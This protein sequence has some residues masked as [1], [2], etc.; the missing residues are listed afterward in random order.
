MGKPNDGKARSVLESASDEFPTRILGA[1]SSPPVF[2]ELG[3][4][5]DPHDDGPTIEHHEE[6]TIQATMSPEELHAKPPPSLRALEVAPK[7]A[8][9]PPLAPLPPQVPAPVPLEL[10]EELEPEESTEVGALPRLVSIGGALS[11][12]GDRVEH[13]KKMDGAQLLAA[14]AKVTAG[15]SADASSK[16]E[17]TTALPSAPIDRRVWL[18]ARAA[19]DEAPVEVPGLE[20]GARGK[21]LAIAAI[22]VGVVGMVGVVIGRVSAPKTV[23]VAPSGSSA[24]PSVPAIGSAL[25]AVPTVVASTEPPIAKPSPPEDEHPKVAAT[26]DSTSTSP[27]RAPVVVRPGPPPRGAIV[28][29]RPRAAPASGIVR[30]NPF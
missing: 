14:A 7:L 25:S 20:R 27:E 23:T 4:E 26:P 29:P 24:P 17:A 28:A 22:V 12:D 9:R 13:T 18:E 5:P 3:D 21:W 2:P 10:E 8:S 1:P 16:R 6:P 19:E 30:D 15:A 11:H